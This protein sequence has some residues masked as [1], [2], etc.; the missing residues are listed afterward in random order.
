MSRQLNNLETEPNAVGRPLDLDQKVIAVTHDYVKN[1]SKYGDIA[2]SVAGLAYKL[3]KCK[4]TLYRWVKEERSE[5]FSDALKQISTAQERSL[6]N[7]GLSGEFNSAITKLCLA[8]NH[9]YSENN[10]KDTGI[11][12]N[13]NRSAA[14]TVDG[15]TLTVDVDD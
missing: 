4:Q 3:G 15:D 1:Y 14:V 7:G 6:L 12:V 10:Q 11:T 9:G 2:P 13:V 8:T 5:E